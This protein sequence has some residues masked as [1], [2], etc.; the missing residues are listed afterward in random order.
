MFTWITPRVEEKKE[1]DDK[2]HEKTV[3]QTVYDT[4]QL[5]VSPASTNV[6][7]KLTLDQRLKGLMWYSLYG[8]EFEGV[9]TYAHKAENAGTLHIAFQF[10][11]AAGV[12]DGFH[13][14][15]AG[16][17]RS[18]ELRPVDGKMIA[19]ID[20]APGD[21]IAY[22]IG[23][24]SRGTDE[25]RYLPGTGVASLKDFRL[26]MITDFQDI[27]FPAESMSPVSKE[28]RDGGWKLD[29]TFRQ[30]VTGHNIGM[31]MPARI[32][33]G[34]LAASLAF[35][36]PISLLFFFLVIFVLAT[37]KKIEIHPVNYLFLG[38]AFFAFH[39]LF[40]Y[41]VD[42]LHLIPAFVLSSVVSIFLVVSYLKLVVGARFA[43][44]EAGLAQLL[45]L[46][47]FSVAHFFDGF[48]GLTVTLLSI[49]TLF[50]LMQLTG[51]IR[52]SEQLHA[53][54]ATA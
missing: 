20:V 18:S 39:L 32:Q 4:H 37:L 21:E 34:E 44:I 19:E 52:W 49:V 15:V 36:A 7:V 40:A 54:K 2:G 47:G 8:V 5:D 48:T 51:R 14:F 9:W 24:K 38:G 31:T 10:P 27:D 11:D 53:K 23:Y 28:R 50:F 13:F 43:C 42:H 17:D 12:Y 33:P 25:W 26:T 30:V 46:V 1:V 6:D 16:K 29:W 45:Y 35:S 22:S 41:S 3:R